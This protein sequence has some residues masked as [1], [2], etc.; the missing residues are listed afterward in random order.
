MRLILFEFDYF[1]LDFVP[2]IAGDKLIARKRSQVDVPFEGVIIDIK[3]DDL[4]VVQFDNEF[5]KQFNHTG[6]M[7]EFICSR[8]NFIRMH[9][10]IDLALETFGI[11]FLMPTVLSPRQTPNMDVHLDK[12]NNMVLKKRT[13]LKWFNDKLNVYQRQAVANVL[14]AD[15]LNPYIIH[16]PPGTFI[17]SK[18]L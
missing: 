17:L 3:H 8:I 6:Y 2:E 16:G 18:K 1:S 9:Y 4:I 11:D 13:K 7:V 12:N 15:F 5:V 10:A 14:R